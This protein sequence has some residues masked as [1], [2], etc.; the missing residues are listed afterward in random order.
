M[1]A[2]IKL[3]ELGIL[4]AIIAV[5]VYMK[6]AWWVYLFVFPGPDI[7]MPGYL[8]GNKAGAWCYNLFHHKGI[9]AICIA[10]G[11]FMHID[12]L[13]L[14]GL[15]LFGYSSMDRFAGYGLKYETGF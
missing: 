12:W 9:A 13:M 15:I 8:A 6:V 1:Q 5:L 3:E 11:F 4:L 14:A 10:A 7:S 2:T